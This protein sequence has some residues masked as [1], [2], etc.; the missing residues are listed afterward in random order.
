[1]KAAFIFLLVIGY[2]AFVLLLGRVVGFNQ[3]RED[4]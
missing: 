1:L 4:E 2:I 3:F